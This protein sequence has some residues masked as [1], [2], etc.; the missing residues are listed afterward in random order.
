MRSIVA[1]SFVACTI[2]LL[3]VP[4]LSVPVA[5]AAPAVVNVRIEGR[6]E[7]LFE[8]PILTDGR[9][10]R[11]LSD[12]SA[13]P[14]GHRC[15]GLNNAQN[16]SPGPTPT[17]A[18][19]DAMNLLGL[20]F[21]GDWY[22][23]FD[24]YF[25]T[26]WGP[27][28]EDVGAGAYWG[29]LVN[30]VFTGVGGCQYGL[31]A[32]DEVLWAHDAFNGRPR[33]LLYPGGYPGGAVPLTA[34]ATLGVPFEVEVDEWGSY[35]EGEPPPSPTR[36]T[37]GF[38]GAGVAP[39]TT[40]AKGFQKVEAGSPASVV[41]DA[42]GKASITFTEAGWHRIKATVRS[43]GGAETVIR[44]NRLD[45]CVPEAPAADC[46]APP[47][48]D[49]VRTPPPPEEEEEEEKTEEL[50]APP[51]G[52]TSK[53]AS[54][55]VAGPPSRAEPP[56]IHVRVPQLNRRRVSQGLVEVSWK[57]LGPGVGIA[58]WTIASLRIGRKEAHYVTRATG[59]NATEATLR[60]PPGATYRLRFTITDVLGRS[61]GTTI[62]KVEVPA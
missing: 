35:N 52:G 34:K 14:Q 60:L 38:E 47:T 12:S 43:S 58:G 28:R 22:G 59:R 8:G 45:V 29:L 54:P 55:P 25:I 18:S 51:A 15:N 13:P 1:A 11:A 5:Y 56:Q 37:T 30:N 41:T 44:S 7:T 42:D 21:D 33:L 39:V 6:A 26:Q 19:V 2:S 50:P 46:G 9:N 3:S 17:A 48:D 24:D 61:A 53:A 32:G 31:D 27:D 16:P 40:D 23:D 4:V 36:S 10:V 57:V 49:A 62:G 20:G